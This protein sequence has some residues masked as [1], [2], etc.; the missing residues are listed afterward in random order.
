MLAGIEAAS[1]GSVAQA[2]NGTCPGDT[3]YL[4]IW[5]SDRNDVITGGANRD[6]LYGENGDDVPGCSG[7]P[8]S[9]SGQRLSVRLAAG[10]EGQRGH[11][12]TL[13]QQLDRFIRSRFTI[14]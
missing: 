12:H 8:L 11:G 14:D 9:G 6:Q 13:F 10:H 3:V 2:A 1:M 4:R 7:I 5:G